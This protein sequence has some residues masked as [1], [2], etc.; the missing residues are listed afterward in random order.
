MTLGER[1]RE[2]RSTAGLSQ[3]QLAESVGVSRQAVTK[4][5]MDQSAPSTRNLLK[6]AESLAITVDQL[7]GKEPER[8]ADPVMPDE[9]T[10][11]ALYRQIESRKRAERMKKYG[12]NIR[13]GLIIF[14]IWASV[15]LIGRIIW[16]DL[17]TMTLIGC[18]FTGRPSGEH[19]YL[20]GWLAHGGRFLLAMGI[21]LPPAFFGKWRFSL[22]G[23]I[24][25][26][27]GMIS[28]ILFGPSEL[29]GYDFGWA[30]WLF[31]YLLTLP[32]GIIAEKKKMDI[33]Q[34]GGKI[35]LLCFV[36]VVILIQLVVYLLIPK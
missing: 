34:K 33:R 22:T 5:E 4:W 2:A 36:G 7:T 15:W 9:E 26:I 24:L 29:P 21:S 27:V 32:L 8:T 1:I 11:Y 17:R 20:F 28:G 3:E 13:W 18:F 25:F 10:I 35:L 19:S 30:Y 31:T 14:S 16:C 6:I 12:K 23:V